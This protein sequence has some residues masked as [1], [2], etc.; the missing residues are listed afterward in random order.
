M[1]GAN[2]IRLLALL[3]LALWL[4]IAVFLF[5]FISER[6]TQPIRS[7]MQRFKEAAAGNLDVRV[8]P[9]SGDE[10]AE[11]GNSFNRMVAEIKNLMLRVI[12]EHENLKRTELKLLQAQ[13]NPHFLYNTL[14]TIVWMAEGGQKEK[15][16]SLVKSLSSFFRIS[17]SKGREWVPISEE[18]AHVR[19][20]LEVQK[21]RYE[22]IL[23]FYIEVDDSIFG[24][25]V[26][27]IILQPI[28]ENA[29]Y[30]GVK[31]RRR[32]G[33]ISLYGTR[34]ADGS[35]VFRVEDNGVGM[36]AEKLAE[37]RKHMRNG[38]RGGNLDNGFGLANVDER[39]R[40]AFGEPY[41]VAINS[42]PEEGT[43]VILTMPES[44]S[45]RD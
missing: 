1:K 13:I 31:S 27:K 16:V 22:D 25:W 40:L 11:L 37:V 10:V 9:R 14:D 18:L 4:V 5:L 41:G 15:V 30:H 35:I 3:C 43:S 24:G 8:E 23:D 28:I 32:R 2:Q 34:S 26:P 21:L 33:K 29:L 36:S 39:I 19:S 7:I 6:L 20:Y 44:T 45:A 38:S 17:L 42:L 12:S